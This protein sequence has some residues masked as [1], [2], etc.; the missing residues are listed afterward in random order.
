LSLVSSFVSLSINNM[1]DIESNNIIIH[2]ETKC[3][4]SYCIYCTINC[5]IQCA[6][7]GGIMFILSTIVVFI[8]IL[9]I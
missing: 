1:N 6:I 2:R 5:C 4:N 8:I 3:C 9:S 7:L